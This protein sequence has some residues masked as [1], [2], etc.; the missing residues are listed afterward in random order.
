MDR[1]YEELKIVSLMAP[2]SVATATETATG[3]V[4]AAG[5]ARLDI[6]ILTAALSKTKTL[7]L[8][9]YHADDASGTNAAKLSD[10]AFTLSDDLTTG[11]FIASVNVAGD[12]KGYYSAKFQH[13][14]GTAVI[15]GAAALLDGIYRPV[16]NPFVV[17]V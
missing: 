10:G 11:A 15:C 6:V 7:Q 12:R 17:E 9:V 2:A 1:I 5:A 3:Y 14:Q 8:D 16:D 13:D 4:S